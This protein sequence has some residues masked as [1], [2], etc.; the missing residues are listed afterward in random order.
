M[1]NFAAFAIA[2]TVAAS[3]AYTQKYMQYLSSHGKSYNSIEEF[4]MRL[5]NF[6]AIDK[7]I[8]EWNAQENKTSTVGHNFLSDWTQE[9]KDIISGKAARNHE[10]LP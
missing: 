4:N 9:E 6:I 2:G 7:F 1:K 3:D 8:E 5:E 10:K